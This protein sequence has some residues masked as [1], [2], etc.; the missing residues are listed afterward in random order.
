MFDDITP[1]PWHLSDTDSKVS[2]RYVL[3]VSANT[4]DGVFGKDVGYFENA[5]DAAL[6]SA[7][8]DMLGVLQEIAAGRT[9]DPER[10]AQVFLE[11]IENRAKAQTN[12]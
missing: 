1:K 12:V 9:A 5:E 4:R 10:F 3:Y 2:P 6:C 7:A 11:I 8:P